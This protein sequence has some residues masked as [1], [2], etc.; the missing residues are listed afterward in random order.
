MNNRP[1]IMMTDRQEWA[2]YPIRMK[3]AAYEELCDWLY[4]EDAIDEFEAKYGKEATIE[5]FALWFF[6]DCEL[7]R[8]DEAHTAGTKLNIRRRV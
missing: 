3:A 4:N 6:L 8:F 1:E 5:R 2:T 7:R